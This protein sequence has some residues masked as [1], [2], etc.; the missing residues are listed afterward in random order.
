MAYLLFI[1]TLA[2]SKFP[3]HLRN[4]S[5]TAVLAQS[6]EVLSPD[7]QSPHIPHKKLLQKTPKPNSPK[8]L[9]IKNPSNEIP[10]TKAVGATASGM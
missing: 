9:Q 1:S 10:C 4:S 7:F 6:L 3:H 2:K 5:I 8:R